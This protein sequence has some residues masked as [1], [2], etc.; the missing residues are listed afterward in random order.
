[1]SIVV[2]YEHE[3]VRSAVGTGV[4]YVVNPWFAETNSM[5][6]FLLAGPVIHDDV[7]VMNSD[8][9]FDPSMIAGLLEDDGDA[10]L[11][12]SD[13]GR[14]DEEMK[15]EVVDGHLVEMAKD[16]RANRVSGE[17]VGILR[18]S[19]A[20]ALDIIMAAQAIAASGGER[21]WLAAAINRVAPDHPIRCGDVSGSSWVE[22]D[23]P[24]D[25]RRARTGVLPL[26][27]S[28]LGL[29]G[30]APFARSEA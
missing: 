25:L 10:L 8:L 30:R 7:V 16:L 2:G 22:I 24:E 4:R 20:T 12:D 9:F 23:F 27:A 11:Y 6:S 14:D 19:V 18:L 15:V 26:I 1:V 13:S 5:Y 3:Q 21:A 28:A 29:C 17:S